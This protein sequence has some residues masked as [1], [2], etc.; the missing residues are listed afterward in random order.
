MTN[1][2]E[3]T[4]VF[5]LLVHS[6]KDCNRSELLGTL[7]GCLTRGI[8]LTVYEDESDFRGFCAVEMLDE[9]SA[10]I[11]SMPTSPYS[12]HCMTAIKLWAKHVG[13]KQL[14]ICTHRLNGSNF[15]YLEKTL[16]FRRQS[17]I[18]TQKVD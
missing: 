3:L 1:V 9:K 6:A 15:R 16:G 4:R 8:L 2:T 13:I 14:E 18:F 17:M 12:I 5:D 11:H 7:L 10:V